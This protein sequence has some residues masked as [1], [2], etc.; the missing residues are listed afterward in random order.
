M[1]VPNPDSSTEYVRR[2]LV[3]GYPTGL[4]DRSTEPP[5][6]V[7]DRIIRGRIVFATQGLNT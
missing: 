1:I 4:E 2:K 5:G 3:L 7:P 6:A